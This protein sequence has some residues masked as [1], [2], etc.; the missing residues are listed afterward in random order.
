MSASSSPP[1][2]SA[3]NSARYAGGTL[4]CPPG[5]FRHHVRKALCALQAAQECV[6]LV[7]ATLHGERCALL[8]AA[9]TCVLIVSAIMCGE[10]CAR[11]RVAY[12]CVRLVFTTV[13]GE[14]CALL[15]AAHECVSFV[16]ATMCGERF[17][18]MCGERLSCTLVCQPRL[19]HPVRGALRASAGGTRMC[20]PPYA[21]SAAHCRRSGSRGLP[22]CNLNVA[23]I[24]GD[25]G[26][27]CRRCRGTGCL[28]SVSY[29]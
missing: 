24:A 25:R 26:R 6:H 22:A 20:P 17:A 7:S 9:H 2:P 14:R 12:T 5:C 29:W 13:C 1:P 27:Y 18:T 8:R 3:G 15:Q 11:L 23:A 21:G 19:H 10:C 28:G 16:S 4:M